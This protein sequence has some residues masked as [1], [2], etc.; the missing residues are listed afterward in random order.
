MIV[1]SLLPVLVPMV[2]VD[3]GRQALGG[4]LMGSIVTGLFVAI[5]MTTGARLGQRKSNRD[6]HHGGKGSGTRQA[7][8]RDTW[9]IQIQGYRGQ[10]SSAHTRSSA[11][12][13]LIVP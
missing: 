4:V 6:G 8:H 5:S 1:A 13:L 3:L 9:A 7:G 10:R 2:S 11:S 12:W